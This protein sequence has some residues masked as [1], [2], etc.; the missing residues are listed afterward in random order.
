MVITF[1]STVTNANIKSSGQNG[2]LKLDSNDIVTADLGKW[3]VDTTNATNSILVWL[4]A[5]K[6][7]NKEKV[8]FI[9]SNSGNSILL[10]ISITDNT[11]ATTPST[12]D[13]QNT[14]T[15]QNKG[16][17]QK[18]GDDQT[19]NGDQKTGDGQNTADASATGNGSKSGTN[20]KTGDTSMPAVWFTL[21]ISSAGAMA[22]IV[23][24]MKKIKE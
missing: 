14:N 15:D 18:T 8:F 7:Y 19:T 11:P 20:V 21:L 2:A 10:E 5:A 3:G 24:K 17:D 6:K 22:I 9:D 13:N 4:D 23:L 12:G 16:E 1:D